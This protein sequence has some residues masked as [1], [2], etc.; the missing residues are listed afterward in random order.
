MIEIRNITI[1]PR[2]DKM[3][4]DANIE[5]DEA[6]ENCFIKEVFIDTQDTYTMSGPSEN[7]VYRKLI[8]KN[9]AS[10]LP[11]S[12]ISI[13]GVEKVRNLHLEI[14]EEEICANLMSDFF[15]VYIQA[16][17]VFDKSEVS[18]CDSFNVVLGCCFWMWPLYKEFMNFIRELNTKC[19][20]PRN[21][22]Y[23]YLKYQGLIT[24]VRT[25]NIADA[26]F[27]YSK[28]IMTRHNSRHDYNNNHDDVHC[29]C[30][31]HH[32]HHHHHNCDDEY[33]NCDDEYH[34]HHHHKS[35]NDNDN[36][37]KHDGH[38]EHHHHHHPNYFEDHYCNHCHHHSNGGDD[39]KFVHGINHNCNCNGGNHFKRH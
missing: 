13:N 23:T 29:G 34:H 17:G 24:S 18:R 35:D 26:I 39:L 15:V 19:E 16:D 12:T 21:F 5:L 10:K 1:T 32:H 36:D 27:L 28:Y 22:I 31:E 30:N 38:H 4:I 11:E 25:G 7:I 9:D 2:G 20:V 3:I 37:N 14:C 33:H 6:F 8:T